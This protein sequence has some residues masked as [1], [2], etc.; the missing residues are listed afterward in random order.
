M[1]K[2]L[3]EAWLS[4]VAVVKQ[5]KLEPLSKG[6]K[7]DAE[8]VTELIIDHTLPQTRDCG[9][10]EK[11][12]S[13]RLNHTHALD[14]KTYRK[15]W[16][17]TCDTCKKRVDLATGKVIPPGNNTG[18]YYQARGL[19]TAGPG[20]TLGRKPKQAFWN[21]PVRIFT[22]AEAEEHRSR[23]AGMLD[24]LAQLRDNK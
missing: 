13:G 14:K 11:Q 23:H 24:R 6:R 8:P 9:F 15:A 20:K 3:F 12:C 16:I 22:E 17:T 7:P 1:D 4:E 10:C 21:E 19:R 5:V 18:V 2:K